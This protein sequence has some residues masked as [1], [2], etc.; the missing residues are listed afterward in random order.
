MKTSAFP[1]FETL[2]SMLFKSHPWHGV[3]PGDKAPGIVNAYI[4]NVPT[5]T[6]KHESD[7][8]TGHLR[9]DRP[10]RFSSICPMLYGYIP[11]TYCGETVG[12]FCSS[13]TGIKNVVGDGDP[14]DICVLSERD[15][16]HGDIFLTAR[17][18][19]GLRMVDKGQAD[20][21]IVAVLDQD[22]AFGD[23]TDI[24]KAPKALITRLKHYFLSY[25]RSPDETPE[26]V[27]VVKIT[28]VYGRDEALEVLKRSKADYVAKFGT[29]SDRM[30]QLKTILAASLEA[31]S[32]PK[33]KSK[34]GKTESKNKTGSK[35]A[36]KKKT[37][38]GKR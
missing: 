2:L 27:A 32:K 11:Q 33:G 16:A 7:K 4:E 26:D 14:L 12:K 23:I 28:H 38:T 17:I 8:R 37:G 24:S 19:G 3:A 13:R 30:E 5:E 15:F 25:K 35:S 31:S 21:K 22:A 6:V 1:D 29:P 36:G 18:I 9:V 34:T 20:D 10:H